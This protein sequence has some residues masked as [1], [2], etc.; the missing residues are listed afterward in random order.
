[1]IYQLTLSCY[2]GTE[3]SD[4]YIIHQYLKNCNIFRKIVLVLFS[5]V[6]YNRTVIAIFERM[7]NIMRKYV[8]NGD[9]RLTFVDEDPNVIE[10]SEMTIDAEIPGNVELDMERAGILPELFFGNNIKLLRKYEYYKWRYSIDIDIPSFDEGETVYLN[11]G[12]VDCIADYYLDGINF[13]HSENALIE[14]RFDITNI[15]HVGKNLLEV[16]I[17]SPLLW[18][19][20][21]KYDSFE[22]AYVNNHEALRIRKAPSQYGWDIMPRAVT[23]GIWKDITI[24]IESKNEFVDFYITTSDVREDSAIITCA[25]Q[26]KTDTPHFSGLSVRISGYIDGKKE[27]SDER[28]LSFVRSRYNFMVWSPKLWWPRG[29]KDSENA[30]VYDIKAELI[31][32]GEVIAEYDTT[33]GIRT[34]KLERSEICDEYGGEFCFIVNGEKV[35]CHGSNWV[36]PDAFPSRNISRY[37]MMLDMAKDLNCNILRC[38]GGNVYEDDKFFE[39]CDRYGI[40]VWQDFAM[41]CAFYPQDGEF[42]GMLKNEAEAVVKRLRNHPSLV[43]WSGDNECDAHMYAIAKYYPDDNILTRKVLPEVIHRLDPNRSYL[44]SSPYSCRSVIERSFNLKKTPEIETWMPSEPYKPIL[45]EDHPWGSRDYY[46]SRY[47]TGLNCAFISEIGYHGCND[48]ESIKKFISPDKLWHWKDN[49]EWITHAAEMNG[50]SGGYAYRIKLMADQVYELFGSEPEKLEDFIFASQVSQAEADKYFIESS[51]QLKW[52]RS[53]I[54]WWNLI[55]G[56]EQFSDAVVSYDGFKKLAYYYIRSASQDV[57]LSFGEPKD[58]CIR[59]FCSND[60]RHSAEIEYKVYDADNMDEPVLK[61]R[62]LVAA[63]SAIGLSGMRISYAEKKLY[64]IEWTLNGVRY[65]NHYI[66]GYPAFGIEKMKIWVKKIS[67]F[68]GEADFI[69]KTDR[70]C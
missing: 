60:T 61:G 67:E 14:H 58:W 62:K 10:K 26:V 8:I 19:A 34:V 12:G 48:I 18:A 70:L 65:T 16:E 49:D 51:R 29:Y 45:P 25:F 4:I 17:H 31:R 7:V 30:A 36:P 24:E 40:M 23:A 32:D 47:Y 63:N 28:G 27:F 22:W 6:M 2:F 57:L 20:K 38:W 43:L 11:F 64:L 15:C 56:W 59:L 33:L 39:L 50:P 66:H 35:F 54:I 9:C 46:K 37:E 44:P 5:V 21:Q 69:E 68:S 13:G 41:A 1:M 42:S 53:G 52:V 3:P 55:D